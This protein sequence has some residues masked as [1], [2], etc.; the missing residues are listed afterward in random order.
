MHWVLVI[1]LFSP[2]G[3]F[4]QKYNEGPIKSKKE[5]IARLNDFN[6]QPD[7]FGVQFKT[8]CVK[9]KKEPNYSI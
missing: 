3:E 9:V 1:S 8:Q 6:K 5:C 7:L 2:S 4:M